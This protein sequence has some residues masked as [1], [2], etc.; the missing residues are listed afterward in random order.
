MDLFVIRISALL[1]SN[2]ASVITSFLSV[3]ALILLGQNKSPLWA[4][5]GGG[6]KGAN[7]SFTFSK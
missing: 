6:L 4:G 1:V 3:Q 5:P 2:F 7:K